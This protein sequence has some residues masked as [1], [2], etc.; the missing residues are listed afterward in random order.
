MQNS[1]EVIFVIRPQNIPGLIIVTAKQHNGYLLKKIYP[2]REVSLPPSK[3]YLTTINR[4]DY[5]EL[6]VQIALGTFPNILDD[7]EWNH[8][9][10]LDIKLTPQDEYWWWD[11]TRYLPLS[12]LVNVWW[13]PWTDHYAKV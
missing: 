7:R 13:G 12:Q 5:N 3:Q 4:I 11:E 8:V 9:G 10:R 1:K 6:I 2:W